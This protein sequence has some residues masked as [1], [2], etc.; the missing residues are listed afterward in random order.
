MHKQHEEV[1]QIMNQNTML[2]NRLKEL[3]IDCGGVK[4]FDTVK[5]KT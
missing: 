3:G 5:N 2:I 4:Q 1:L